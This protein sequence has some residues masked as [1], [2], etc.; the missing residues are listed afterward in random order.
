MKYLNKYTKDE[1]RVYSL[2]Y[3]MIF[4]VKYKKPVFL[5]RDDITNDLK[6]QLEII[7]KT[8][9]V[10]IIEQECGNDHIHILFSAK[11]TLEITKFIN[12][13]KGHSSR[14]LRR[15]YKEYLEDKLSGDSFWSSSYFLSTTGN[16]SLDILRQYIEDQK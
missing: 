5:N 16:V 12:N 1:H 3:H 14:F 13:M 4:V 2:L 10:D 15:E 6:S 7:A 8:F 9:D 11:P